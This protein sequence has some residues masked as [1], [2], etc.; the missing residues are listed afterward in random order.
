ME[1]REELSESIL[2]GGEFVKQSYFN[3]GAMCAKSTKRK[4][5]RQRVPESSTSCLEGFLRFPFPHLASSLLLAVSPADPRKLRA[6]PQNYPRSF[7]PWGSG[8]LA[9]VAVAR[10][11]LP[12]LELATVRGTP[13]QSRGSFSCAMT[14]RTLRRMTP[15]WKN[16]RTW[17]WTNWRNLICDSWTHASRMKRM[18]WSSTLT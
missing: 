4:L 10:S 8:C 7:V 6:L 5:T 18:N 3:G 15:S 16:L 14:P 11:C 1:Q 2:H 9:G 12:P 17:R 13:R